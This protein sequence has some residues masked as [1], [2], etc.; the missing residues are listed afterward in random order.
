MR[1]KILVIEDNQAFRKTVCR[2]LAENDYELAEAA[3]GKEGV[4][5]A[6]AFR[7]E[8]V[9]LD[10]VLPGMNGM[11]VCAALKENPDTAGIPVLILTG[12]D[13]DGQEIACLDVGAD[14]YLIKPVKTEMLLAHCRALLRRAGGSASRPLAVGPLKLDYQAKIARLGGKEYSNL[15]PKE[16]DLLFELARL[17][18]EPVDRE[19]LYRKIWS[20]EPPSQVSV[21]TVDVHARRIRLK[22]GWAADEWLT[23]V[24]GRGYRLVAP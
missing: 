8:L 23:F 18:P 22:L 15:T 11:E 24:T 17:S 7:P 10:F 21:R 12:N 19:A 6:A 14:D 1:R 4:A 5:K 3:A 20:L 9:I 13:K 2:L 16:F